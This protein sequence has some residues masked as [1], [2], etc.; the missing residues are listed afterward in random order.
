MPLVEFLTTANDQVNICKFLLS[1]KHQMERVSK[2]DISM[3]R[4]VVVDLGW[5]LTNSTLY[6]FNNCLILEYLQFCYD[7]CFNVISNKNYP[8][9]VYHCCIHF[10]RNIIKHSKKV[11]ID[12]EI[13]NAFVLMVTLIQS[14][15]SVVQVEYFL[16]NIHTILKSE[17]QD[18]TVAKS[19]RIIA[20][21]LKDR[22]ITSN[23]IILLEKDDKNKTEST[24]N[25]EVE[26]DENTLKAKSPFG[27][28]FRN[29]VLTYD[30]NLVEKNNENKSANCP[31]NAYFSTALFDILM[32]KIHLLP[33]WTGKSF[34]SYC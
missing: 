33:L 23:D 28:Y 22:G 26:I 5:T 11:K 12:Q 32:D 6:A 17:Y 34:C 15:S 2:D 30:I 7:K 14:S 24:T 29:K 4:V 1:F 27:I 18:E 19:L 20:N 10:I 13:R 9:I 31:K 8:V 21:Q 25:K 16:I 3:A